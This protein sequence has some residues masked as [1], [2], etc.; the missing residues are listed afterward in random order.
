LIVQTQQGNQSKTVDSQEINQTN[1]S[2]IQEA[3]Y[4]FPYHYLPTITEAGFRQHQYW[5][6]GYRYLG[7]LKV[8]FD[9]LGR[10]EFNSLLDIGCGD[11]RF[12]Y[13]IRKAYGDIELSGI[14]YSK[15]ALSLAKQMNPELEFKQRDILVS[16]LKSQWDVITLLEVIEHI[17]PQLLPDF[18][19]AASGMLRPG[20]TLIITVP[21][22]NEKL[23]SKHYQHFD[24][25]K[26]R[27]LLPPDLEESECF[28]FDRISLLM[29]IFLKLM[30]GSGMFY[31]VSH[32][33][34]NN[35]FYNHYVQ[36]CLY[37]KRKKHSKKIAFMARKKICMDQQPPQGVS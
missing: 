13:E 33:G 27:A 18:I 26:I 5:S 2:R 10:I 29:K 32:Q 17:P 1:P 31:I 24:P 30:G 23:I 11:G 15:K 20:G 9:L 35:L 37:S 12:L 36:K 7:R 22:L 3:E 6:W 34:L 14:D 25:K 19:K 28:L 8:V 16:P 4:S 21:H